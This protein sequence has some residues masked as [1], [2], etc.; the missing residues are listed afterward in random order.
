MTVLRWQ[1]ALHLTNCIVFLSL[2]SSLVPWWYQQ[3][4][5]FN[6]RLGRR[7]GT[8]RM[9]TREIIEDVLGM[10]LPEKPPQSETPQQ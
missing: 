2:P 8:L 10:K 3:V 5:K 1:G 6:R 9:V 4:K 7:D